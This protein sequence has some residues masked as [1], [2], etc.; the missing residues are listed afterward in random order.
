MKAL[1]TYIF[2]MMGILP[3]LLITQAVHSQPFDLTGLWQDDTGG[4][5]QYRVRQIGDKLF[6]NVD[7]RP[8]VINV[9]FGQISGNIITGEWADLP[10]GQ[11]QGGGTLKL[12][13]E[14]NNRMVKIGES[15][16]YAAS[17][18]TRQGEGSGGE[19]SSCGLGRIWDDSEEGWTQVWTRR[20]DS[21]VF[22][23][24]GTKPGM[25][26]FTAVQTIEIRGNRV[27]VN[28]TWASDGN[29]C[30]HEGTIA[31]DGI[32]VTGTYRCKSGGPYSWR[33][34][35]RCDGDGSG[36][37]GGICD[38][39]RTLSIMDEWLAR[40]IPPQ[41]PGESL[42]YEPWGRLVG[43]S[44]TANVTV[45]GPPDTP[46]TRCKYLWQHASQLRSTS[47]GTLKEYVEQRR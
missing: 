29:T 5:A 9:F 35:I 3:L 13:I 38:D 33:A 19:T 24:R 6:W 44:L 30:E 31:A 28:R 14:S 22:D 20:G 12:R 36:G 46:L 41:K 26:T 7:A 10:G 27:F 43:R 1:R 17:I 16:R 32:T 25:P 34:T 23:V 2:S 8:L 47:L 39:P 45:S 11:L 40:A 18:W 21:N 15:N 4:G 37:P 42:R